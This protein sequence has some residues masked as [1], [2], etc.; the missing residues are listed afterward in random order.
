MTEWLAWN[1]CSHHQG[2]MLHAYTILTETVSSLH[3]GS[4][5]FL[6]EKNAYRILGIGLGSLHL[7]RIH[8][9]LNDWLETYGNSHPGDGCDALITKNECSMRI[10]VLVMRSLVLILVVPYFS[11]KD[12]SY[13]ILDTIVGSLHLNRLRSWLND[14][15]ETYGISHPCD[16]CAALITKAECSMRIQVWLKRYL[17]FMMVPL[18]FSLKKIAYK[19]LG[20][21]LGSLYL[22]HIHFW[23]SD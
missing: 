1:V 20:T 22:N 9:W 5:E 6:I 17:V 23:L 12:N 7:N 10:Q 16:G 3:V 4:T 8:F 18:S 14:W 13:Q 2:G 19:I 21:S 15:L 11:L